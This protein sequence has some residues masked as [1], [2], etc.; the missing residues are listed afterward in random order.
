MD[1]N[2]KK[3][4]DNYSTHKWVNDNYY[5]CLKCKIHIFDY[6][7]NRYSCEE[8]IIKNIIK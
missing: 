2:F 1:A 4:I 8:Q 3:M 5:Y 6:L 7:N